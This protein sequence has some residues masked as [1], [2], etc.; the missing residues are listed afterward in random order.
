MT[1]GSEQ[2]ARACEVGTRPAGRAAMGGQ[3]SGEATAVK[4]ART[5]GDQDQAGFDGVK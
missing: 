4:A 1:A 2:R 3:A 5:A